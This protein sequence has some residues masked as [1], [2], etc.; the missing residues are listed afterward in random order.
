MR[1][2]NIQFKTIPNLYFT[3]RSMNIISRK[4][5]YIAESGLS[6]LH[7]VVLDDTPAIVYFLEV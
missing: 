4:D 6:L 3:N 2:F 1:K 7:Y 5:K